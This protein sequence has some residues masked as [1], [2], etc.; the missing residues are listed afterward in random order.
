MTCK[1]LR[2]S[3][4]SNPKVLF[5]LC[6]KLGISTKVTIVKPLSWTMDTQR[7]LSSTTTNGFT[8]SFEVDD[9]D[10]TEEQRKI[11]YGDLADKCI[12]KLKAKGLKKNDN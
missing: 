7:L 10:L 9:D 8:V 3:L 4:I 2:H 6:A 12:K 5:Y 11:H 1:E